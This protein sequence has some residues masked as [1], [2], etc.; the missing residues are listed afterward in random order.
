MEMHPVVFVLLV[1]YI[2]ILKVI[3]QLGE[4]IVEL[5]KLNNNK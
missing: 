1:I 2:C 3:D 4:V 5:K